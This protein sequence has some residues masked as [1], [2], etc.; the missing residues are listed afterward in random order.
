MEKIIEDIDEHPASTRPMTMK[1]STICGTWPRKAPVIRLVNLIITRAIERRASDI[2]FEPFEDDFQVRYRID[3][4]LH[5]VESPPKRLQA[6]IISRIKIMAKLNIAERRL[7]QDGRIMLRVQ[8]QGDRL[9]RLH[10]P[11]DPR[12]EPW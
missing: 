7:P 2:H 6:A 5:D 11:H 9:P 8:G 3:G 1:T 10:H 4:I 12:G